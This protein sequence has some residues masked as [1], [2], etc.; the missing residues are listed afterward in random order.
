VPGNLFDG[1]VEHPE[2]PRNEYDRQD[3]RTANAPFADS[4]DYRLESLKNMRRF[5]ALV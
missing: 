5:A 4:K 3:I 2:H 1:L